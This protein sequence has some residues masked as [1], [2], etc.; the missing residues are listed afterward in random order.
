MALTILNEFEQYIAAFGDI[1]FDVETDNNDVQLFYFDV[2]I[3]GTSYNFYRHVFNNKAQFNLKETLSILL[4][5]NNTPIFTDLPTGAFISLPNNE[6][7]KDVILKISE[8]VDNEPVNTIETNL[9]IH[10]SVDNGWGVLW[11]EYIPDLPQ[12]GALS[13]VSVIKSDGVSAVGILVHFKN[14]L[15]LSER[16]EVTVADTD[17]NNPGRGI[18][19]LGELDPP[20]L[21]GTYIITINVEDYLINQRTI[22]FPETN[23]NASFT[24]NPIPEPEEETFTIQTRRQLSTWDIEP[25]AFGETTFLGGVNFEIYEAVQESAGGVEDEDERGS[26]NTKLYIKGDL[27]TSGQTDMGGQLSVSLFEGK[28]IFSV[29]RTNNMFPFQQIFEVQQ[30]QGT[31]N[32]NLGKTINDAY[33]NAGAGLL[34]TQAAVEYDNFAIVRTNNVPGTGNLYNWRVP[35]IEDFTTLRNV[36]HSFT[37]YDITNSSKALMSLDRFTGVA[38]TKTFENDLGTDDFNFNSWGIEPWT[39]TSTIYEFFE[40]HRDGCWYRAQD[41]RVWV[42]RNPGGGVNLAPPD[43]PYGEYTIQP[44]SG[45]LGSNGFAVRLVRDTIGS[46]PDALPFGQLCN[47]YI[48]RSGNEYRAVRIFTQVWMVENLR[49]RKY[50]QSGTDK[51]QFTRAGSTWNGSERYCRNPKTPTPVWD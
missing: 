23:W 10:K 48:D 15:T 2:E 32:F 41:G 1:K 9:I 3:D 34:Y 6:H 20:F 25:L 39:F 37:S 44:H 4:S 50:N 33:I 35:T 49:E 42:G 45:T 43:P 14:T 28:Y 38:N 47:P 31:I 7:Q 11:T 17:P 5:N 19:R 40:P 46:D 26:G 22:T 30:N 18:V 51:I 16:T 8:V 13:R 12:V 21:A 29:E 27:V 36:L 24:L